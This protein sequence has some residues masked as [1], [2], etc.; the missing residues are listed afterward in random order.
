MSLF[1]LYSQWAERPSLCVCVGLVSVPCNFTSL[2]AAETIVSDTSLGWC[3][4]CTSSTWI[5]HQCVFVSGRQSSYVGN[6]DREIKKKSVSDLIL[7]KKT[8]FYFVIFISYVFVVLFRQ[9]ETLT[10]KLWMKLQR[11]VLK[12]WI[13]WNTM[14]KIKQRNKRKLHSVETETRSHS[15]TGTQIKVHPCKLTVFKWLVYVLIKKRIFNNISHKSEQLG[16]NHIQFSLYLNCFISKWGKK[17]WILGIF[18]NNWRDPRD[19]VKG[20]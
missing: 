9:I 15:L 20:D 13:Y 10:K 12:I 1:F 11:Q 14:L 6:T 18:V 17:I 3:F 19:R 8:C 7:S 16:F 2:C 4:C 5:S